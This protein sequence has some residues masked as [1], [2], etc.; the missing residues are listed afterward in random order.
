MMKKITILIGLAS[1]FA[2]SFEGMSCAKFIGLQ[3]YEAK[4]YIERY[5]KSINLAHFKTNLKNDPLTEIDKKYIYDN[6]IL[7]KTLITCKELRAVDKSHLND[8]KRV[9]LQE[10]LSKKNLSVANKQELRKS[11]NKNKAFFKNYSNASIFAID[12][13]TPLVGLTISN[14]VLY[15][16]REKNGNV[17]RCTKKISKQNPTI[18]FLRGDKI[19]KQNYLMFLKNNNS[20]SL[21][22]KE[23]VYP[24]HKKLKEANIL[25]NY[26]DKVYTSQQN[27]EQGNS[28]TYMVVKSIEVYV[29]DNIQDLTQLTEG[30][31][32]TLYTYNNKEVCFTTKYDDVYCVSPYWWNKGV[33]KIEEGGYNE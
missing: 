6:G 31:I 17:I 10:G 18:K 14:N 25:Q 9:L 11:L 2:F 32:L 21:K 22:E 13:N 1:T 5:K 23:V 19:S 24:Q 26:Q 12:T 30:Q 7:N 15:E 8:V 3:D 4:Q 20:I 33:I 27:T 29:K 16:F 28:T